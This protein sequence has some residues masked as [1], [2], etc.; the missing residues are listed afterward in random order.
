MYIERINVYVTRIMQRI[1]E[2]MIT[3]NYNLSY[4][5]F[6]YPHEETIINSINFVSLNDRL[7]KLKNSLLCCNKNTLL[8]VLIH[9]NECFPRSISFIHHYFCTLKKIYKNILINCYTFFCNNLRLGSTI[10][11]NYR[12]YFL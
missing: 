1:E 9:I 12:H 5:F 7:V 10:K 6:R 8:T 2:E 3:S 11:I 4:F